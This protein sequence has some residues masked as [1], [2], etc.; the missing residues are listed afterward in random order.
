[1]NAR[2]VF[3]M[4]LAFFAL[5]LLAEDAPKEAA[6]SDKMEDDKKALTPV[7][8][9]VGSWKGGPMM[10]DGVKEGW[11][12]EA[13]WSWEFKDG[14]AALVFKATNGHFYSAGKIAPGEAANSF[15][16]T[17]TLPDGKASEE[18]K[19][20]VG[21][22]GLVLTNSNPGDGRPARITIDLIARGKRLDMLY[23]KKAGERYVPLAEVGLTRQGSGFGKESNGPECVITGG[24]GTI[25]VSYKGKTYYVC[26]GGCKTSFLENPEKELAAYEK[27]KAEEAAEAKKA[28]K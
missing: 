16:F 1:M 22:D 8:T 6:K 13:E 20:E 5:P 26:C 24:L 14:R 4:P 23:Q 18:L 2:L 19:G 11:V 27:R 12:E 17:G 15:V 9:Y 7:K 3:I 21:K 28:Q 25:P 10:K